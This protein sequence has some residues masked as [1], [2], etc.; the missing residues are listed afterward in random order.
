MLL[1]CA[2]TS[3]VLVVIVVPDKVALVGYNLFETWPASSALVCKGA[4]T[5]SDIEHGGGM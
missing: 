2:T 1:R 4:Q 3:F 5:G